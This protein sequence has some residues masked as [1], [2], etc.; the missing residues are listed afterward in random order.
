MLSPKQLTLTRPAEAVTLAHGSIRSGKTL[1]ELIGFADWIAND[2]PRGP[3]AII[4]VTHDTI[5]RNLLEQLDVI[6]PRICQWTVRGPTCRIMGR[7]VH[8]ISANDTKA[9]S[10]IRGLTLAGAFVDEATLIPEAMFIQL[11]GRL[12]TPGSKLFASTNPD[13][14]AHWLKTKYIDRAEYLEW[15]VQH[16]TMRDNPGLSTEYIAAKE[17]E[18]TGLYYR[19]FILG[20]WVAAEGAIYPNFD[21]DQHVIDFYDLPPAKMALGIG[22]DYGTT[23]A[24][25]AITLY[26]GTDGKLYLTDEWR[27]D[28]KNRLSPMTDSELSNS[29]S[30]WRAQPHHP[31]SEYRHNNLF[32]DPAAA[33]FKAQLF[34]DG[35]RYVRNALNDVTYGIK[36]VASLI[37]ADRLRITNRCAG[38]LDEITGYSWDDKAADRGEDRPVKTN[39]HSVDAMRY[40]ITSS[41]S[42]WRRHI[43]EI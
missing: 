43:P 12:S 17:K 18:F 42:W 20:E 2:A 39:D 41:E 37:A 22:I 21:R 6:D 25:S 33:S 15:N 26:L 9:E 8:R 13:N 19:R 5:N 16:F 10:K 14:P 1:A 23:N 36:L 27:V 34:R 28:Q 29:F 11:L 40:A 4:G 31:T 32:V 7:T 3:L 38:L 24:S 35:Q 30:E